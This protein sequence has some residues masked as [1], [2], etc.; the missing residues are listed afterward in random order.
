MSSYK[1]ADQNFGRIRIFACFC[2]TALPALTFTWPHPGYL[3]RQAGLHGKNP[4]KFEFC[5]NFGPHFCTTSSFSLWLGLSF[6]ITTLFL[7]KIQG[8]H[9]SQFAMPT[10]QTRFMN[11]INSIKAICD[12]TQIYVMYLWFSYS[13]NVLECIELF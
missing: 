12:A 13:K 1:S 9:I 8:Q 4:Q 2:H 3:L 6:V 11:Q 10:D 7:P 5:Q